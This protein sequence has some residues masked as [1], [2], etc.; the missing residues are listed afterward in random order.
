MATLDVCIRG[1][2]AVG[3]TLALALARQGLRVGVA[4]PPPATLPAAPDV[5]TYAL[6]AASRRLLTDL[7]V[8]HALPADAVTAVDEMQIAGDAPGGQLQFSAWQQGCE[9]LA[10]IVDAAALEA[11]LHTAARFAPHL[12]MLA[13]ADAGDAALTVLAEGKAS[14]S[15]D[16]LGVQFQRQAYGHTALAARL[17]ADQPHGGVARQWFRA[18]DVLA[19]LPFDRPEPTR[20]YGL[21]WSLPAERAAALQAAPAAEVEA[22]LADATGGAAGTLR[23]ASPVAAW[24]LAIAQAD[25]LCGPGWVLVGDA[26]HQVHPLAGQGLN[27]GLADAASL[28]RVIAERE[29]WRTLGDEI[30]L[31]RHVRERA[32]PTRAMG[33][34]TDSLLHLFAHP[35]PLARE[36]RNR[37]MG[38]LNLLAPLKRFLTQRALDA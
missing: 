23:L 20:S 24:P 11:T 37:G 36:L 7:R 30:L 16:A 14:A 2:G 10:W 8:W 1:N 19:L 38:L 22:A 18:P 28:A 17:V 5:R 12:A 21:V 3:L 4:G 26:A 32:G 31:R 13:E 15:R 35:Q 33:W 9:A 27:L 6:N 34:V 25:R 29:P